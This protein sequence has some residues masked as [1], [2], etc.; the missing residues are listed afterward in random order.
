MCTTILDTSPELL[1]KVNEQLS[2]VQTYPTFLD[3]YLQNAIDMAADKD[4]TVSR[5]NPLTLSKDAP[6][7]L[8]GSMGFAE[9]QQAAKTLY[10]DE[11]FAQH[12]AAAGVV[13]FDLVCIHATFE[14]LAA[15]S[16]LF[17]LSPFTVDGAIKTT[18]DAA[19]EMKSALS[20]EPDDTAIIVVAEA[21]S[22]GI[23]MLTNSAADFQLHSEH[24]PNNRVSL[25]GVG[26]IKLMH[27]VSTDLQMVVSRRP[28]HV[29]WSTRL[30]GATVLF[31]G[32]IHGIAIG[33]HWKHDDNLENYERDIVN[34]LRWARTHHDISFFICSGD[35]NI[36]SCT[37]L[38]LLASWLQ[39][40]DIS[41][42]PGINTTVKTRS[43]FQGQP[44][45][46]NV[47]FSKPSLFEC[48]WGVQPQ[49]N[50]V[51]TGSAG[52]ESTP[53]THWMFDHGA[54]ESVT[55]FV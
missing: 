14:N 52:I 46:A 43:N 10:S 40:H 28:R 13:L 39:H 25:F 48:R 51:M 49:L 17:D 21:P 3:A 24:D 26:R 37:D 29:S 22:D 11:W 2:Q 5:V 36:N 50:R 15:F 16:I 20:F 54:I 4:K 1:S 9:F 12:P 8:D 6:Y 53:N 55:T 35:F 41:I 34:M 32:D 38:R 27:D 18:D 44:L 33:V 19:A 42:H 45:K 7:V 30:V 23:E 31:D 47:Q